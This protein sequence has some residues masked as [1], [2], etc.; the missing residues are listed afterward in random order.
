MSELVQFVVLQRSEKWVVKS[1]EL[2]RAFGDR[3]KAIHCAVELANES[4]KNGKPALVLAGSRRHEFAPLWTFGKDPYPLA[5]SVSRR[6]AKVDRPARRAGCGQRTS[7]TRFAVTIFKVAGRYKGELRGTRKGSR[8]EKNPRPR[9]G[10]IDR[11][12]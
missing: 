1:R 3:R 7:R 10:K 12:G 9:P 6:L 4:G 11:P 2:E 5:R 8:T